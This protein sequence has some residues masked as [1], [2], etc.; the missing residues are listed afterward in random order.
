MLIEFVALA[1]QRNAAGGSLISGLTVT[2]TNDGAC[3]TDVSPSGILFPAEITV[4]WSATSV[5]RDT[6][7]VRLLENGTVVYTDETPDT[8]TPQWVKT[9]DGLVWADSGHQETY[10][11]TTVSL[12]YTLQVQRRSDGAVVQEITSAQYQDNYGSCTP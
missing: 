1:G 12:K 2:R 5:S 10:G 6:Y 4:S 3:N 7:R 8:S 11:S 9:L